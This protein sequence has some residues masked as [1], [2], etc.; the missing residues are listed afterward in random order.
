M[1]TDIEYAAHSPL[2]PLPRVVGE[3]HIATF[4]HQDP[5][6]DIPGDPL[7]WFD[8][9]R[10]DIVENGFSHEGLEARMEPI[11]FQYVNMNLVVLPEDRYN[12]YPSYVEFRTDY[13][14]WVHQWWL[15]FWEL[16][17][18]TGQPVPLHQTHFPDG[19]TIYHPPGQ[20]FEIFLQPLRVTM[21][22]NDASIP[23]GFVPLG[24][25]EGVT[26]RVHQDRP[27]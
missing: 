16:I 23:E 11:A 19:R 8:E 27:S 24:F 20:N 26:P 10:D 7:R 4:T 15:P 13:P 14:I 18:P 22:V 5:F 25:T 17:G 9:N 6:R 21:N 3:Q 12:E 1:R 2:D